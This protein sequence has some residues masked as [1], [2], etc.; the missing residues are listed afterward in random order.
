MEVDVRKITS[1]IAA[2]GAVVLVIVALWLWQHASSMTQVYE[3]PQLVAWA[4]R[5]IGIALA[6]LAQVILLALVLP[7]VYRSGRTERLITLCAGMVVALA[8][9]SAIALGL[10]GR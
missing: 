7:V 4:I 1:A 2:T 3:Q 10:A 5:L 6:A 9:V 8:L